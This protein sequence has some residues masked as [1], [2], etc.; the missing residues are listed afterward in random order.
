M[1][2]TIN[3]SM[4]ADILKR[5]PPIVNRIEAQATPE[6]LQELKQ[7]LPAFRR[8]FDEGG[9][10]VHEFTDFGPVVLF[11]TMFLNGWVR[12]LDEV[13]ARRHQGGHA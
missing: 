3:W 2:V 5:D 7:K 8:A 13:R 12:L 6:I 9:L 10:S 4:A 1:Y 11:R